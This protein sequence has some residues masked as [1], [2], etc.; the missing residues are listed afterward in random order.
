MRSHQESRDRDLRDLD[1][2]ALVFGLGL[3][4]LLFRQIE[5][6]LHQHIF[7][8]GWLLT[9]DFQVTTVLYYIIFLPGI[10]LHE[11]TLWLAAGVFNVRA[12]GALRFPEEQDISQLR[13]SV[14]RLAPDTGRVK[15]SLIAL[16]PLASGL[17]ALCAIST[18]LLP[19]GGAM[20]LAL[21][22]SVTELGAAISALTR[23]A[24][25][26]LW[27]Y[28]VFTIAN[29]TFPTLPVKLAA[30]QKA[31]LMPTLLA[32]SIGLWRA[33]DL[34]NP[35]IALRIEGLLGGLTLIIAQITLLNIGCVLVLGAIEA[36]IERATSR[37]AS[38]RDG[39]L[40]TLD[41]SET[42]PANAD[43]V[44]PRPKPADRSATRQSLQATSIYD[45]KLPI[46]GPPGREPVS[47]RAVTVVNVNHPT[48]DGL[49]DQKLPA[50][51]KA[52]RA[53]QPPPDA[54][55]E[56]PRQAPNPTGA[57]HVGDSRR[58]MGEHD[59]AAP[60]ARPFANSDTSE[61]ASADWD[62]AVDER[63]GELFA[64][65]FVMN[66]R[67]NPPAVA[68]EPLFSE[69]DCSDTETVDGNPAYP[70]VGAPPKRAE[71]RRQPSQTR[72]APKLSRKPKGETGSAKPSG[73]DELEYEDLDDVDAYD[74]EVARYDDEP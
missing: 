6:W 33:S 17:A 19:G 27:L 40:I 50:R 38:F 70:K 31:L 65:P 34:A 13:L 14:T 57:E 24:N 23:T 60:F 56:S 52:I 61:R 42:A 47:R 68:S 11:L 37:S 69:A 73:A 48:A 64:R 12:E 63:D 9:N 4:V 32:L 21:P 28:I 55:N 16:S 67:S 7:K 54:E 3:L 15:L 5:R 72:P 2:L 35:A 41:G 22:S 46:P 20:V 36:L 49:P 44:P 59:T 51:S 39:R 71:S 1:F 30:R 43:P 62:K 8:V 10:L 18:T 29:R 66:T 53:V 58:A 45:L 74:D 26:W 25:F